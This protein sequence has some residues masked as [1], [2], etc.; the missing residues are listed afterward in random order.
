VVVVGPYHLGRSPW[1]S[2]IGQTS[3]LT[4]ASNRF[5]DELLVA[6][7]D[8]GANVLYVDAALHFNLVVGNPASYDLSNAVDPVCTSVDPGPGIGTGTGQ[9]N[10]ALCTPGTLLP[11]VDVN[12]MLFADRIYPTPHGHRL[13]GDYAYNRIRARW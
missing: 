9:I 4:E 2:A 3:L 10:S 1:A 6:I 13:F 12:R 7:V 5:N 8:L 11:G